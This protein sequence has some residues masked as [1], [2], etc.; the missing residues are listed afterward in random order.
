MLA[1][2]NHFPLKRWRSTLAAR[3]SGGASGDI[4]T[5]MQ[6][7]RPEKMRQAKTSLAIRPIS[8]SYVFTPS[9]RAERSNPGAYAE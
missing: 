8:S 4:G 5:V 9:L 3:L 7:V 6:A 1:M 2:M